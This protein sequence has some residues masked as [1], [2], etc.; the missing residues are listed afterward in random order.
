MPALPFQSG[1]RGRGDFSRDSIDQ[2][3]SMAAASNLEKVFVQPAQPTLPPGVQ[4][5]DLG[6]PMGSLYNIKTPLL[7][8]LPRRTGYK[9][10]AISRKYYTGVNTGKTVAGVSE[11]NRGAVITHTIGEFLAGF[12]GLGLENYTTWEAELAAAGFEDI[13]DT[14]IMQTGQSLRRAQERILLTGNA[15]IALGT[16]PT[17]AGVAGGSGSSMTARTVVAKIV[18]LTGEG[19]WLSS[20]SGGVVGEITRTNADGSTDTFGGG[21][22][23]IGS[24]SAGVPVDA[25]EE[26]TWVWDDVPGAMHYAIY[27]GTAAATVRLAGFSDSNVWVQ[28]ADESGTA[29]LGTAIT[30]DNSINLLEYDGILT[31]IIKSGSGGYYA[32]LDGDPLTVDTSG[33]IEQF[34]PLFD[35][36]YAADVNIQEIL[37]NPKLNRKLTKAVLAT[38]GQSMN[39]T[40][41]SGSG[42]NNIQ[43]GSMVT[44]ILN[45]LNNQSI[46]ITNH[47][48]MPDGTALALSY[49][50]DADLPDGDASNLW[51][52]AVRQDYFG[53]LWPYRTRKTE[54]GLYVDETLVGVAPYTAGVIR[55]IG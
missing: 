35:A 41:S 49:S 21:S 46:R 40:I 26:I 51:Y 14:A 23:M 22:S 38:G 34:E 3:R 17:P 20:L 29:Q 39:I 48:D 43:T 24:A 4:F 13:V 2:L 27:T 30:A 1:L 37:I 55:N 47:D 12:K 36:M 52:M 44:S 10:T 25:G 45:Q 18:A 53:I 7:N 16:A 50:I 32:S 15:S 19:R 42:Q 6:G 28:T 8:R 5:V 33:S 31:Q 54:Y 11:G 9:G